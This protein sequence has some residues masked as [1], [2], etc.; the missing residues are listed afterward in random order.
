MFWKFLGCTVAFALALFGSAFLG[1]AGP[2]LF[3]GGAALA[4]LL[5]L[6]LKLEEVEEKLDKL[7]G[8]KREE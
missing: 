8:E 6:L 5:L 2:I 7:L 1:D 4:L 3:G